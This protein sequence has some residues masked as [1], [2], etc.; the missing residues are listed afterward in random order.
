MSKRGNTIKIMALNDNHFLH[1]GKFN[2]SWQ[3][4]HIH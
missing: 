4:V 1:G 3:F 2:Q